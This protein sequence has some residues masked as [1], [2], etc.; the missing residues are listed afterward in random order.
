MSANSDEPSL[1]NDMKAGARVAGKRASIAGQ[2]AKT[3]ADILLTESRIKT[4]KQKFGVELYDFL[5]PFAE[6]DPHF[7]IESDTLAN[8]Q[9]LFVEA[10]KDNKA[11]LQKKSQKERELAEIADRRAN[12]FP[13]PAETFAGKLK[14]AGKSAAMTGSETKVK[15]AIAMMEREMR[16]NKQKFGV[17]SYDLLVRLE[18]HDKW[19]PSDRD[20]RFFY[21]QARR[22]ITQLEVDKGNMKADLA[23]LDWRG[24]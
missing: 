5:V 6:K 17:E 14:N 8:I 11:I 15:T 20:V 18:D 16:A 4:R 13:V 10:F 1:W 2:K 22:D 23:V 3:R 9:G 7:I 19:L 21:D 24:G 12:A